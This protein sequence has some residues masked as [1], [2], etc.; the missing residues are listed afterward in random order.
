MCNVFA[1]R[2]CRYI[3]RHVMICPSRESKAALQLLVVHFSGSCLS[4]SPIP[5][6]VEYFLPILNRWSSTSE[7]WLLFR[8]SG[9]SGF[10]A[11]TFG[12]AEASTER[13][14]SSSRPRCHAVSSLTPGSC[15][16]PRQK[17]SQWSVT[18]LSQKQE[19]ICFRDFAST[20]KCGLDE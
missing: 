17:G 10:S 12:K 16:E 9:H 15:V 1:A 14:M 3:C 2:C 6:L 7:L 8:M 4:A 13:I 19:L 5:Y 18:S 11:Q 20:T